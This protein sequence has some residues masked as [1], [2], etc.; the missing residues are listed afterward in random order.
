MT[1]LALAAV[2]AVGLVGATLVRTSGRRE[3]RETDQ[4][5]R[6]VAAM[7]EWRP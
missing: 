6:F 5:Q 7:R 1:A 2:V 3:Y 4:W